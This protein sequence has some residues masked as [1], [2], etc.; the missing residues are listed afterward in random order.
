MQ[1]STKTAIAA[2][3]ATYASTT[4]AALAA[5]CPNNGEMCFQWGIPPATN[6]A[7][8]GNLYFQLRAPASH[9]W[10]ALGTGSNM[11]GSS[12]FVVH[13]NGK[14]VTLST[15][16][17]EGH[18]MPQYQSRSDVRLLP[19]SG[20]INGNLVANV[21][22]TRCSDIN[23]SDSSPW[24]SARKIGPP[25]DSS[26]PSAPISIHDM[27]TS[28]LVNLNQ[29]SIAADSNPFLTPATNG[30]TKPSSSGPSGVVST[31]DNS[32]TLLYAHGIIMAVAFLVGYPVG[33]ALMP[34]L[35]KWV[36]HAG[37][38]MLALAA[39]WAGFA[40]GYIVST[41]SNRF[42]ADSHMVIGLLVIILMMAQPALGWLHHR[43]FLKHR[44]R[45]VI[46]HVHIWHGRGLMLVGIINGGIGLQFARAP[47]RFVIAYGVV[48]AITSI[49]YLCGVTFGIFK[50]RKEQDKRLESS[51]SMALPKM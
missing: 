3:V 46:S 50:R 29:A 19:G 2:I 13:H 21:L 33:A 47:S 27:Y 43:H 48:A 8:S 26:S 11:R 32:K 34:L 42:L 4:E 45:G 15:R 41:R 1:W 23:I 40:I 31:V 24:L 49:L 17:G 30:G 37:W 5:F 14:N 10:F 25:I 6:N 35:G 38:Q 51:S 22:C 39:T 28:F 18:R 16:K 44:Q 12:M 7:K 36:I 9:A 20:V